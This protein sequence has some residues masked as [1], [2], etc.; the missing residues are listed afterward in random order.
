MTKYKMYCTCGELRFYVKEKVYMNDTVTAS[1]V[2]QTDGS[3]PEPDTIIPP[4][5]GC[6]RNYY[7]TDPASEG[8]KGGTYASDNGH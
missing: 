7:N 3:T 5:L 6:G 8:L 2:I 4:C 1:N